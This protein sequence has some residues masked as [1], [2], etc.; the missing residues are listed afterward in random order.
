M[1]G[2]QSVLRLRQTDGFMDLIKVHESVDF[3]CI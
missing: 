1:M 3:Q 2:R